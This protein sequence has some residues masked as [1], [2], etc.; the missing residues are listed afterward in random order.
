MALS[1]DRYH[2]SGPTADRGGWRPS[3]GLETGPLGQRAKGSE[4]WS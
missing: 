1:G 4:A 2:G 3:R